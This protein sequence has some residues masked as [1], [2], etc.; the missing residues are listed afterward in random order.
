MQRSTLLAAIIGSLLFLGQS[1]AFAI[2]IDVL[3]VTQEV[4][5]GTSFN[6]DIAIS[7]LG[8]TLSPSV[9]T[10]D[11]DL[12]FDSSLLSFAGAVFGDQLDV[13]GLGNVTAVDS[14]VSGLVNLY[15]LS[16]DLPGDLD[17]LQLPSFTLATLT[18]DA[19]GAGM[20]ALAISVNALGDANG[21][22]LTTSVQDTSV[23]VKSK[24]IGVPEPTTLSLFILGLLGFG[25]AVQKRMNAR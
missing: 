2:S 6:V 12:T 25:T 13:F 3:P 4:T 23:T 21:D 22:P 10:Y 15:E 20:S 8:D 5:D 24:P 11:L 7:G 19:I 1:A 18:F 17:A 16:L 9:S 14:S